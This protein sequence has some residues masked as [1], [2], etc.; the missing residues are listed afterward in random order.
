MEEDLGDRHAVERLAL[1]VLDSVD[2]RREGALEVAREA[3]LHLVGRQ[4]AVLPDHRDDRDIDLRQD[5]GGHLQ[6]R[7]DPADDDEHRHDDERVGAPEGEADD[8]HGR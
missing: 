1:D 4:A 8:P 2:R 3:L 7:I 6:D 5:V